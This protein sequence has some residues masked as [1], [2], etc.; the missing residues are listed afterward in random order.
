VLAGVLGVHVW[1]EGGLVLTLV[2]QDLGLG[3]LEEKDPDKDSD[4]DSASEAED[5]E[6]EKD[7]LGKL[8]KREKKHPAK[9]EVVRDI[10][11][12]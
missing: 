10:T 2:T 8:L 11:S 9:I 3:V 5:G 12:S 7:V 6:K 4:D 1:A